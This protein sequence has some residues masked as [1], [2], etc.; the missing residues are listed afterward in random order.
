ML[1]TYSIFYFYVWQKSVLFP[2]PFVPKVAK[3]CFITPVHQVLRINWSLRRGRIF[4]PQKW[5]W[6]VKWLTLYFSKAYRVFLQGGKCS[7]LGHRGAWEISG[8]QPHPNTFLSWE[9]ASVLWITEAQ[10]VNLEKFI[11]CRC[12]SRAVGSTCLIISKLEE[13]FHGKKFQQNERTMRGVSALGGRE[14]GISHCDSSRAPQNT[15]RLI[16]F[17]IWISSLSY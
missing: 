10:R 7:V 6:K 12:W 14:D 15:Y 1:I 3:R 8:Y 11:R 4:V 9:S 5:L 2:F 17:N 13:I 16:A